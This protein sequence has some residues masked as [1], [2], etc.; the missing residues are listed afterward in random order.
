MNYEDFKKLIKKNTKINIEKDFKIVI[1]KKKD[2]K[3]LFELIDK[4][5]I[6]DVAKDFNKFADTT[7]KEVRGMQR[8]L[9]YWRARWNEGKK[10]AN[11]AYKDNGFVSFNMFYPFLSFHGGVEIHRTWHFTYI[12]DI[13]R[14]YYYRKGTED[15]QIIE[16]SG[17][18]I[19]GFLNDIERLKKVV[20]FLNMYYLL[21]KIIKNKDKSLFL[22]IFANKTKEEYE[23]M[24]EM[25]FKNNKFNTK[26]FAE[27]TKA[28]GGLTKAEIVRMLRLVTLFD[29]NKNIFEQ[30]ISKNPKNKNERSVA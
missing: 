13:I 26:L 24:F 7:I 3:E 23:E 18:Q 28:I 10:K 25:Y 1:F 8:Y 16:F 29:E 5:E 4:G 17:R 27:A 15:E 11:D 9:N 30:Q 2:I 21:T 6:E 19:K 20:T 22:K 12:D 14:I